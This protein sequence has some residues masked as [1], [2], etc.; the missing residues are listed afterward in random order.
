MGEGE[1]GKWGVRQVWYQWEAESGRVGAPPRSF[2]S[3]R[4]PSQEPPLFVDRRLGGHV[5]SACWTCPPPLALSHLPL[6]VMRPGESRVSG[7]EKAPLWAVRW[8][9]PRPASHACRVPAGPG[10]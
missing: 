5:G 4:P 2:L 6:W 1:Q 8:G 10:P 7:Q 3:P 9:A